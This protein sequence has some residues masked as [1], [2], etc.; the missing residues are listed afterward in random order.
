MLAAWNFHEITWKAP[1]KGRFSRAFRPAVTL[2]QQSGAKWLHWPRST[3]RHG[4]FPGRR[5]TCRSVTL[6]QDFYLCDSAGFPDA[7]E[8][9]AELFLSDSVLFELLA[10]GRDDLLGRAGDELLVGQLLVQPGD[11]LGRL[12]QFLLQALQLPPKGRSG[13]RAAGRRWPRRRRSAPIPWVRASACVM[14]PTRA[15][16]VIADCVA[17]EPLE[18]RRHWRRRR[19]AARSLPAAR[20]SPSAPNGCRRPGRPAS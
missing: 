4:P 1:E 10:F 19:P 6:R 12:G 2:R 18:R 11:L 3:P 8:C 13:C 17:A 5:E 15:S 7:G 20:S 14:S 9:G 16:R